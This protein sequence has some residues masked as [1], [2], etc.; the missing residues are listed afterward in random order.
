MKSRKTYINYLALAVLLLLAAVCLLSVSLNNN[1]AALSMPIPLTFSGE[2]SYDGENWLPLS[3]EAELSALRGSVILRGHLDGEIPEGAYLYY[4]RN[5]IGVS[6]YINGEQCALDPVSQCLSMGIDLM[7]SMCGKEWTS[8]YSPGIQPEDELEIFLYNPHDHGNAA[9]YRDFLN[10]LCCGPNPEKTGLLQRNLETYGQPFRIAG[11]LLIV[12]AMILLGTAMA[13]VFFRITIGGRLFI[14]ALIILFAGGFFIFDA[15]DVCF[16][17]DLLV[18][19]TYARQLCMMLAVSC[20]GFYLCDVLTGKMQKAARAAVLLSA[21]LNAV[22]IVSSFTGAAVIYDTYIYWAVSQWLLCPL[23]AVCCIFQ[24]CRTGKKNALAL[25]SGILMCT[26]I[27]LD[28]AGVGSSILSHGNCSKG[29]FCILF[30][31]HIAAA[32]K[33]IAD[34]YRAS[35]QVQKLEKELQ[36]SRISIMLSQLRPHFLF[37]VLNSIYYLCG[38]EPETAR[39]MIDKFSS[40]LRN[41]LASLDQKTM[42]PFS[43][44]FDHIQTY[45]E[46]EKLRFEEE[47]TIVYDIQADGF[48][49]PAMTVQPLV[50]NAVKHGITKKRG[51]GVLALAT[52]EES[53]NYVITITDTGVGFDP[54]H[55]MDDGEVHIGIENVR[56]RLEHMANGTLKITSIPGEGTAAVIIIPKKEDIHAW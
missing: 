54:E 39:K 49:L 37:N 28:I 29:M 43:R 44:E 50:E 33:G 35:V 40:Y 47:L 3:E 5:H 2:Y 30:V 13:S 46:L 26:A 8:I 6:M 16:L 52:R 25:V 15:I 1:Q 53:E 32:A 34:D 7:S 48:S 4:Y 11:E 45:L 51:G 41:N 10:T 22:L 36:E 56:Q 42:I 55:Y 9:A 21:L 12:M 24:L 38:K 31:V 18:L 23:L 27:L 14:M 17:I 20:L 19:N